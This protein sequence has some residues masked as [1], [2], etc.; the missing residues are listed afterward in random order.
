MK[1]PM[2]SVVIPTL[3]EEQF[4]PNL[5]ESLTTQTCKD[6]DVTVVDGSS[7]DKTVVRATSFAKQLPNLRVL[8]SKKAS[9]PLQRNMGAR[10]SKGKWLCFL[11]ADGV[12]TPY[13]IERAKWFIKDHD[14][15]LMTT[16]FKP[17]SENPKDAVYTLFGNIVLEGS[18]IFKRPLPPGPLTVVRRDVYEKVGGYDETHAFHED[19]DFGLRLAKIGVRLD[20]LRESLCVWSFRRFRKEGTFK[21]I[22]QYILSVLPVLLFNTSFKRMPGYIMGGQLYMKKKKKLSRSAFRRLNK[23]ITTFMKELFE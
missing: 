22:N 19:V 6:F 5:L 2:F 11:D 16:W 15:R 1:K 21:V 3:N 18:L 20:V 12:L 10:A 8:V 14:A 4:L 13:F 7:K 17:D 9:L 23:A